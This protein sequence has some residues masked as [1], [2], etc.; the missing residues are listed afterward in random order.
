MGDEGAKSVTLL[1]IA[2]IYILF[3]LASGS[4]LIYL[5]NVYQPFD[6]QLLNDEGIAINNGTFYT[7]LFFI[8]VVLIIAERTCCNIV[9][10]P[11]K[12]CKAVYYILGALFFVTSL[13][14]AI[15]QL[16]SSTKYGAFCDER[17]NEL[18]ETAKENASNP[19]SKWEAYSTIGM[20]PS[21]RTE[22]DS[23]INEKLCQTPKTV[24]IWLGV[25]SLLLFFTYCI[26]PCCFMED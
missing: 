4:Y 8:I 17:V 1:T 20:T 23:K 10:S 11:Q 16:I 19:L 3:T 5:S 12:R 6:S 2:I 9:V 18:K 14:V 21:Q 24:S 26:T 22:F 25:I 13:L 7:F 15:M